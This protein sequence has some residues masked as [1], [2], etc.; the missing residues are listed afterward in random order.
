[1]SEPA[2]DHAQTLCLWWRFTEDKRLRT[3]ARRR[4]RCGKTTLLCARRQ[5]STIQD[6]GVLTQDPRS[7]SIKNNGFFHHVICIKSMELYVSVVKTNE[8]FQ[9]C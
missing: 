9:S 7:L 8:V 5:Y 6:R 2:T 1:M 4:S 3:V